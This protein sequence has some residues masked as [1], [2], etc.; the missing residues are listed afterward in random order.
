MMIPMMNQYVD[1]V[2]FHERDGEIQPTVRV[3][4]F[5]GTTGTRSKWLVA[6]IG[7]GAT[8]YPV[9]ESDSVLLG[10]W[11]TRPRLPK[12]PLQSWLKPAGAKPDAHNVVAEVIDIRDNMLVLQVW[13]R[14]LVPTLDKRCWVPTTTES[15]GM[16]ADT[17]DWNEDA[18]TPTEM[19]PEMWAEILQKITRSAP[20]TPTVYDML[21]DPC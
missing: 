12:W 10:T 15:L 14:N 6:A 19:P 3:G 2:A 9:Y 1:I 16:Y 4:R 5:A 13:R 21:R 18:W 11:Y 17:L 8:I 7:L 20:A